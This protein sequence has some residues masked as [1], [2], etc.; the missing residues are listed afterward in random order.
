[1]SGASGSI[2]EVIAKASED[3]R[4]AGIDDARLEA[5][6]L[7]A[8]ALGIERAQVIARLH[9]PVDA[10]AREVFAGLIAR[11]LRREPLAYISGSREFYGI[12]IA[13][14]ARAL[15]PRPETELLVDLALAE[16]RRRGD[17]LRVADVGTGSGAIACAIAAHAPGAWV[18]ATDASA[19]A[20]ALARHNAETIGVG[21]RVE[22][23][24]GDLL[25][26]LGSFGV[27]VANLPYVSEADWAELQP[28]VRA[29]EPKQALVPGPLGTEANARLLREAP[30][31]L[32]AGGGV[33]ALEM[34]DTQAATLATVAGE[35]FPG[36]AVSVMKDLAGRDRVLVVRRPA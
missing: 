18:C 14:D 9:D 28:E 7:L 20:L 27:I 36:A 35:R 12:A 25:D 13:C 8:A 6:V 10:P 24:C 16:L 19:D 26:G 34:G 4:R 1:M 30:A 21:D 2:A 11:R 33:L 32:D 31:H 3:L 22:F 17:D 29:F 15:I 23:R 5:E